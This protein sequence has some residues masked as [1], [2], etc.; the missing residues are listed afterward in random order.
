M[1]KFCANASRRHRPDLRRGDGSDLER[2]DDE[3][4]RGRVLG[5]A[6]RPP[7]RDPRTASLRLSPRQLEPP[8]AL[9]YRQRRMISPFSLF[10][11]NLFVISEND[12]QHNVDTPHGAHRPLDAHRQIL[13]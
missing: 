2:A 9:R 3:E 10:S 7:V 5:E 4:A 12:T 13:F 6:E 8:A 1:H 11:R